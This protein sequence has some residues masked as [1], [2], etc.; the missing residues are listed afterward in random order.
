MVGQQPTSPL[1]QTGVAIFCRRVPVSVQQPDIKRTLGSFERA[2]D[3]LQYAFP[4]V[5]GIADLIPD[6]KIGQY[7]QAMRNLS[8][9]LTLIAMQNRGTMF[10][11]RV[12]KKPRP[13]FSNDLESFPSGHM[14]IAMQCLTRVFFAYT[15]WLPRTGAIAVTSCIA[16]GRY[17]PG[18]HDSVDL[19]AGGILG[20]GLGCL[21]NRAL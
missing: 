15:H 13:S 6:I 9:I 3:I 12:S 8:I 20:V 18:K 4:T 16:M 7:G 11:K 10:L 19:T 17:L 1:V 21:W 14:M 5:V 2:G